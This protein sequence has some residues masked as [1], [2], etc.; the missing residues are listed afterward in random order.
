MSFLDKAS[1]TASRL[2]ALFKYQKRT[3]AW[4]RLVSTSYRSLAGETT[5]G[6][7]NA[8]GYRQL[9]IDGK[10]YLC[11]RLAFLYVAGEWPAEHVDHIDTDRSNNKW[12]NLRQATV[13][14]NNQNQGLRRNNTSGLKG[15]YFNKAR[16]TWFSSITVNSKVKHLG[17]F[18]SREHAA[19]A[20]R[21]AAKEYHKEFYHEPS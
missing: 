4:K 20:Y 14:Q 16:G 13:K 2:R 12:R 15:A 7:L 1:L 8:N 5:F 18:Q 9:A 17:T 3:G 19:K 11:H 10:V 6:C 21:R